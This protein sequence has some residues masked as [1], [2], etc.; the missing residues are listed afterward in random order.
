MKLSPQPVEIKFS[1]EHPRPFHTGVLPFRSWF[2]LPVLKT[3]NQVMTFQHTK[4]KPDLSFGYLGFISVQQGSLRQ[5]TTKP[6][7]RIN[8][9]LPYFLYLPT[10][11][12]RV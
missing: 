5:E 3:V 4:Q 2:P 8:H 7:R 9:C 6:S 12:E 1:N 10:V 11:E